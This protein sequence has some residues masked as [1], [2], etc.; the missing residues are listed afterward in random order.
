MEQNEIDKKGGYM[1][2]YHLSN[3]LHEIAMDVLNGTYDSGDGFLDEYV[4][5]DIKDLIEDCRDEDD[6]ITLKPV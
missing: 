1:N 6:F 2:I 5:D 4:L 3:G